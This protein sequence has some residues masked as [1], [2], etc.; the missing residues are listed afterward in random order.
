MG[1]ITTDFGAFEEYL[2]NSV[3]PEP[4]VRA[5]FS[6]SKL[7]NAL[8]FMRSVELYWA[9]HI[10][11]PRE[12]YPDEFTDEEWEVIRKEKVAHAGFVNKAWAALL[13]G[14]YQIITLMDQMEQEDPQNP[15]KWTARDRLELQIEPLDMVDRHG[16]KSDQFI[17]KIIPILDSNA[18]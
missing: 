12:E 17:R 15:E 16:W 1:E 11:W 5:D 13:A 10:D 3:T 4:A 14:D 7:E 8:S 18:S 2:I 9:D 6:T